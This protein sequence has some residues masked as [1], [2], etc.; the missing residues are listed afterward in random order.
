MGGGLSDSG[1]ARKKTFFFIDVFPYDRLPLCGRGNSSSQNIAL[2]KSSH[3]CSPP[4]HHSTPTC[5]WASQRFEAT[6]PVPSTQR[7]R[8][9]FPTNHHYLWSS[10]QSQLLWETKMLGL[11]IF[12]LV[13]GQTGNWDGDGDGSDDEIREA[14]AC[15][16]PCLSSV[17]FRQ[18]TGQL[19]KATSGFL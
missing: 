2:L 14:K 17:N 13:N 9:S 11:F 10:D 12:H 19:I 6:F 7:S 8:R 1:N 5:P 18:L 4:P 3:H 15:R 16:R